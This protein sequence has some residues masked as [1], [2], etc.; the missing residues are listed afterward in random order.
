MVVARLVPRGGYRTTC[1]GLKSVRI[2]AGFTPR[3]GKCEGPG[4]AMWLGWSGIR[5]DWEWHWEGQQAGE[6]P[7]IPSTK[8]S[9]AQVSQDPPGKP[10]GLSL[11][12]KC[13]LT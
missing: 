3:T 9:M 12:P 7:A 8:G 10:T 2:E 1:R 4:R 13:G 6:E 11:R 5:C